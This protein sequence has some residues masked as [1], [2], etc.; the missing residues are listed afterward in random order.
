MRNK[1]L[2]AVGL[3]ASAATCAGPAVAA[4]ILSVRQPPPPMPQPIPQSP[5]PYVPDWTGFYIGV[6]GGG[7]RSRT[8]FDPQEFELGETPL[9]FPSAS[10][11]GGIVG[12]QVGYNWQWG[13]V[14]GGLEIDFSSA[15]LHDSSTFIDPGSGTLFS[16]D[17]KIDELASTRGRLGYLI[18]PTWLLYGTAGVGWGHTRLTVFEP[19]ESNTTYANEFGWVAGAGIEWKLSDHWLLR[20]EWLHYDFE[21]VSHPIMVGPGE[22]N[23]NLRTTVDV[24]RA[25]LSYKF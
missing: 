14:V 11:N 10:P 21:T 25:A 4:D 24:G 5:P 1:L 12:G 6:H 2:A 15:D 22:D 3:F 19:G 7:A 20:G 17:L 13:Q 9:L 23:L 18:F 16:R 8:S